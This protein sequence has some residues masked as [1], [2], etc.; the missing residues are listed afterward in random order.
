MT[1]QV[2]FEWYKKE[3]DRIYAK[4]KAEIEA[5][6]D[7]ATKATTDVQPAQITQINNIYGDNSHVNFAT[8]N[9]VLYA[10]QNNGLNMQELEIMLSTLIQ[11]MP[12]SI[13]NTEKEQ[14]NDSIDVIRT[15]AQKAQ[16]EK[17]R[18]KAALSVLQA[19]KGSAEFIAT[20]TEL[21]ALFKGVLG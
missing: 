3:A 4:Y 10:V 17:S 20:V 14:I 19:I 15:E 6:P 5:L 18:L 2:Y 7:I 21:I 1:F 16:P 12:S 13:N 8:N 11:R 9:A